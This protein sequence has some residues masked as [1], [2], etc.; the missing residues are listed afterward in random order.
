VHR[1][2]ALV[3]V[4]VLDDDGEGTQLFR[5]E[6]R[7]HG[8]VGAIPIAEHAEALEVLALRIDLLVRVFAA[9]GAERLGVDLLSHPAVGLFDLHLDRKAMAIPARNVRRVVPVEGAGLDDDVLQYLVDG[10][11]QVN[12]AVRIRGPVREHE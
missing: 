7:I 1:L 2:E 6:A 9:G 5:L 4:A 3:H 8:E 12:G 11:P 10:V